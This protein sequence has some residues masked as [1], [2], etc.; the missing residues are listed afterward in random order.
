MGN[1]YV[2]GAKNNLGAGYDALILKYNE[3]GIKQWEYTYHSTGAQNDYGTSLYVNTSGDVFVTGQTEGSANDDVFMLKINSFGV[4]Q[5]VK[6][7]DFDS[8][9]DGGIQVKEL[10][11]GDIEVMAITQDDV[12]SYQLSRIIYNSLGEY[13]ADYRTNIGYGNMRINDMKPSGNDYIVCGAVE[14]TN[15][16]WDFAVY[17]LNSSMATNWSYIHDENGYDDEANALVVDGSGNVYATGYVNQNNDEPQLAT[18]KLNSSGTQQWLAAYDYPVHFDSWGKAIDL[19]G[20]DLLITG[21]IVQ[22]NNQTDIITL[23]TSANDGELKWRK[24]Y[25]HNNNDIALNAFV[26]D[27]LEFVITGNSEEN[28]NFVIGY[29][30]F[31]KDTTVIL[32]TANGSYK[33]KQI[34]IAFEA[35]YLTENFANN[36]Q[37]NFSKLS[38]VLIPE[39][40]DSLELKLNGIVDLDKA[41]IT[42]IFDSLEAADTL[43]TG[44]QGQLVKLPPFWATVILN[45]DEVNKV[46]T[47]VKT[48]DSSLKYMIRYVTGNGVGVNLNLSPNDTYWGNGNMDGFADRSISNP[49]GT[50]IQSAWNYETGLPSVK[51]GIFDSGVNWKKDDFMKETSATYEFSK[52]KFGPGWDTEVER[53]NTISSNDY[54]SNQYLGHGT[55]VA[56]IIGGL[57]NNNEGISG[58]A[59]GNQNNENTGVTLYSFVITTQTISG[60][61]FKTI[62]YSEIANQ[63]SKSY[64][65]QGHQLDVVNH[66]YNLDEMGRNARQ[67]HNVPG[68]YTVQEEIW[69]AAQAGVTVIFSSGRSPDDDATYPSSAFEPGIIKVG[70][71]DENKRDVVWGNAAYGNLLD[72][73]APYSGEFHTFLINDDS[74]NYSFIDDAANV[75]EEDAYNGTSFGAPYVSGTAA[76]LISNWE[77]NKDNHIGADELFPDDIEW[78]LEQS[79][80][81][82]TEGPKVS[83]NYDDATEWGQLDALKAIQMIQKPNFALIHYSDDFTINM[84]PIVENKG[85]KFKND[86]EMLEG[87]CKYKIDVYEVVGSFLEPWPTD[88]DVG[89]YKLVTKSTTTLNLQK[90]GWWPLN[91]QSQAWHYDANKKDFWP[92]D[93]LEFTL[94]P[95]KVTINNVDYLQATI[96]GHFIYVHKKAWSREDDIDKWFP[97]DPTTNNGKAKLGFTAYFTEEWP[98]GTENLNISDI[99]IFPNPAYNR[100]TV[101]NLK[102]KIQTIRIL[103]LMGKEINTVYCGSQDSQNIEISFL[104]SGVYLV[105]ITSENQ[106][107]TKKLIKE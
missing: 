60:S 107:L 70:G 45:V 33:D 18:A 20:S 63:I 42:K 82:I 104:K 77:R 53:D 95:Q 13:Q 86:F 78:I 89:E 7:F 44:V 65:I 94:E 4:Q 105:E 69:A 101:H 83:A 71:I 9:D 32:D 1:V 24:E 39:C 79:A 91:T 87:E 72:L 2:V 81:D 103:D 19:S 100:I 36:N 76:L 56:G 84:T 30:L 54:G 22:D 90:D 102:G 96:K 48:I 49:S 75:D 34:I 68:L 66:S 57:T 74:D 85:R 3:A 40:I 58:V 26:I 25:N 35:K 12:G 73:T 16:D 61:I 21:E 88:P 5:F 29:E 46:D 11:S 52:S 62:D 80:K 41:M 43:I 59:G 8:A 27:D 99:N 37:L 28:E 38:D 10:A 47:V 23:F 14:N 93:A 106:R 92:Y 97:F 51:V 50:N 6:T 15:G 17:S 55:R 64:A 31:W 98:L 67:R